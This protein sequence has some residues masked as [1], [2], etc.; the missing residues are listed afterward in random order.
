MLLY[1]LLIGAMLFSCTASKT[2]TKSV[3]EQKISPVNASEIPTGEKTIAIVDVNII[4][5]R[6]GSA[7]IG[8]ASCRERVCSTV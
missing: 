1:P 8:R 4:D 5:G 6:G 3:S 7:Q 2:L